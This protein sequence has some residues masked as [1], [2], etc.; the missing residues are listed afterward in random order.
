MNQHQT[1]MVVE[2]DADISDAIASTLEDTGYSVI[3]AANGQEALDKLR[4]SVD[5]PNLI[6]LDLM[7]PLMDGWQFRAAQTADPTLADIPV[8]VLSAHVDVRRAAEQMAAVD[9][10]RK[11]LD[12]NKLLHLV[13]CRA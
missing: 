9:W 11:P 13:E 4:R 8:V 1:I 6:L 10:M 5:R 2:D 12:L 3:V 7:M